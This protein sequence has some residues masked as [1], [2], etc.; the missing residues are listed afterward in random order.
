MGENTLLALAATYLLSKEGK[1]LTDGNLDILSF[2]SQL[3][4]Q[5]RSIADSSNF[6]EI[7]SK[8]NS[9]REERKKVRQEK[10]QVLKD[11]TQEK[12]D[13]TV[14]Y[15]PELKEFSIKGRI[16][17]KKKNTP[18][19]GVKVEVIIEEPI[20]LKLD[21]SEYSTSTLEDGTF[22]I[23]INLPIL[24]FDQKVLLQPLAVLLSYCILQLFFDA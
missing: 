17:D 20:Y 6:E 19:E 7:S 8:P 4:N 11:Q 2:K 10:K 18:L 24:P 23:N 1:K 16:Y 14:Q 12:K 22:E 3:Q 21:E 13:Q 15:I 5:L 9:T